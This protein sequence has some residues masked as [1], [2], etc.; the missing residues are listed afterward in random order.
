MYVPLILAIF[1]DKLG[2]LNRRYF[3]GK[4]QRTEWTLAFVVQLCN[5]S[6]KMGRRNGSDTRHL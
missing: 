4:C 2:A 3:T 6:R 1:M 5:E